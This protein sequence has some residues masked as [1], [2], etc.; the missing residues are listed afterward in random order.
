MD[1]LSPFTYY[2]R[3]RWNVLLLVG[4]ISLA[5]L[6]V[7]IMVRLLDA[8]VEQGEISERYLTRFS[9]MYA[10]G[11]SLDPG[12]V[13]QVRV[14]PDVARAIPEKSLYINTPMNTSGGFRLF[15]VPET[16]VQFL[17]DTCDLRLKEG[18][19]LGP[20]TNEVVLSEELVEALGLR[21]GDRI[22]RSINK[23]YYQSIPTEFVLVGIL[24]G[25]VAD[26][27]TRLEK[28]VLTGFVSYE[29]LD[30]HELYTSGRSGLIAVARKGRKAEVDRFLET[31]ISSRDADVWT[32]RRNAEFLAQGRLLFH[33]IF[34]I[35]DCLV[36]VVIAL[37]VGTIHRIALIQRTQD[38][39]LLHAIGH[40]KN[41]L[42]RWLA[43]EA[44]AVA[45]VGWIGGL[46]LSWLLFASLKASVLPPTV[47]LDLTNVTPILLSAP[48]L[49]TVI[50]FVTFSIRRVFAHLDPVSIIER[51]K[52]SM[53][54]S[55][56]QRS[57]R[58]SSVSPLSPWMFYMRH[59][60]W[61]LGMIGIIA[62]MILG[63][64]LPA[65]LFAVTIDANMF[66]FAHLRHVSVVSSRAGISVDSG[67]TAQVRT[68]AAVARVIP[69]IRLGLTI[70]VPPLSQNPAS[71][72]AVSKG[73]MQVLINLYGMQLEEGRLPRP[74][75]NEIAVSRPA[76][77]N[78]GLH[79]G[80][81]VGRPVYEDDR[82]IPTEMVVVGIL[83]SPSRDS[84]E[85]DLWLMGFASYE[86]LRSHELY[87]P[88]QASLLVVPTEG[89]KEE[90]D[91]WLEES[92]ASEQTSVQ[93]YGT[94][95]SEHREVTLV[96]L[97]LCAV[98]ESVIALVAAVA[99]GVLS[100]IF[101]AQRQDEFGILHAMGHRR[102]WLVL[103]TVKETVGTVTVAWLIGAAVC[104]AGLICLQIGVYFPIGLT[105]D[106]LNPAPWLFTLPMPL[107]VVL[108]SA[109]LVAWMLS[110][111]DPV[112]VIERR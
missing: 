47:E 29:Y 63:V 85:S 2:R 37:V 10:I 53:E 15:G 5:T 26:P 72:Y 32:Y 8:L 38:F 16:D 59:Q 80:D 73:D 57:V 69:A 108:V 111:L 109:G 98:V 103:R 35:V 27:S 77:M 7:C 61:G 34:S 112:S 50:A 48:I 24:E 14:H 18:R 92:I 21:I 28:N 89:H 60:R 45:G 101:F 40:D 97:L 20:R 83:S 79:V 11:P 13:S 55:D 107:A 87:S 39:G 67:V 54:A 22:G 41:R 25:A 102:L 19:L 84:W 95:L 64:A 52:L 70:V 3:H 56:Q 71:I 94:R 68:H 91:A 106:L 96:M 75:S 44:A 36:A 30:S 78:R 62:L 100:Y 17:I 1:P 42:I 31:T 46:V 110:R 58:R 104:I 86:Y 81:K 12:V 65:F 90:L 9:V 66:R 74:R 105:L 23:D 43:L 51:G 4:I 33:L 82:S 88:H 76:A 99:L 6:G 49:L 93:T